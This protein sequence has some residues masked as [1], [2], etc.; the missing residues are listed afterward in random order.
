MHGLYGAVL[1]TLVTLASVVSGMR[2]G[3]RVSPCGVLSE[4]KNNASLFITWEYILR[5]GHLR[6]RT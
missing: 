2:K 3:D 1:V 6:K 5:K 4:A